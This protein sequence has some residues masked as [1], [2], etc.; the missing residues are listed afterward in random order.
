MRKSLAVAGLLAVLIG[1]LLL[2]PSAHAETERRLDARNDAPDVID[3]WAARYTHGL[4]QVRVVAT[5]PDLGRRGSAALSITRFTVFEA[6]YVVQIKKR[7][8]RP[9]RTKLYYFNHFDLEP[10]RCSDVAG[11]WGAEKIRLRVARRCLHDDAQEQ[12]F[13]QFGIQRGQ[14]IDR[15]PAIRRLQRG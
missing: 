12:V 13:A 15:A 2:A 1:N 8:G 5:I 3:V 6:G 14:S 11:T 7:P 4:R 10:R 9:A